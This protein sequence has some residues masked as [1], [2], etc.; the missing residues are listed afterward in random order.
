MAVLR[1]RR[2]GSIRG[3]QLP[4]QSVNDR[5][6]MQQLGLGSQECAAGLRT[7]HVV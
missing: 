5:P 7:A 4:H 3:I 6:R 2:E 1:C